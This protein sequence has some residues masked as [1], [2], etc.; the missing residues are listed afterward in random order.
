MESRSNVKSSATQQSEKAVSDFWYGIQ[1][2]ENN[3]VWI[4]EVFVDN[5]SVGDSWL[6]RGNEI[7]L[8]V[9]TCSGIVPLA[10]VVESICN[11]PIYAVALND[12]YDH[13]GGWSGFK[14]RLC[15]PI[16]AAGLLDPSKQ[17]N[18]VSDYLD[19]DRLLALPY[20][21][22]STTE[23]N[24][25]SAEP[26]QL[27]N[28][29]EIIDLGGRLIEVLHTPGRGDGGISLWESATGCLFTSDMLYDG[30]HGLAWPPSKPDLYIQSLR[31]FLDLPVSVVHGG[32]YG[33]FNRS[34]M[35][36]L[37]DQQIADLNR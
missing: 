2:V 1:P 34:R 13:C 21:G 9:D 23:Y 18:S 26:T 31:R 11:N 14:N 20:A 15:H 16:D 35:V 32:H 25:I 4:R 37:I 22:Y 24:M 5:Y 33:S 30:E 7:D 8:L 36:S 29:G 19:D 10:P 28:D 6:I 12:S 27:I 3:I 17:A